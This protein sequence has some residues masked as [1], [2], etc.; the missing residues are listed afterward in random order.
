MAPYRTPDG[1]IDE[2]KGMPEYDPRT[3]TYHYVQPTVEPMLSHIPN[4]NHLPPWPTE[5]RNY[6]GA[7]EWT[8]VTSEVDGREC[9]LPLQLVNL[10][11]W[12][13]LCQDD[14]EPTCGGNEL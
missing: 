8:Y 12:L 3:F 10:W 11:T 14:A 6:R 9:Q 5:G 1:G 7:H 13:A 2:L 4:Y